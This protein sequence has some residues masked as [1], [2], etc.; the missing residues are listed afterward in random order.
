MVS[1]CLPSDA[2]STPTISLGF[3]LPWTWG[4]SLGLLRQS[5]ATAAYLGG[6][7][8]PHGRPSW[9]WTWSSSCQPSCTPQLPLLGRGVAPL[10]RRPWP[11]AWGRSSGHRPSVLLKDFLG[12]FKTW[13]R[14]WM[15]GESSHLKHKK[16]KYTGIFLED[17]CHTK[18]S[19]AFCQYS[20][21]K[22]FYQLFNQ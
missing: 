21:I 6:G 9:P 14:T 13:R 19:R 7:V 3:L 20:E 17:L 11:W 10:G 5:A 4:I 22:L 8:S 18:S 1:A 15:N 16:L 2:L 12:D